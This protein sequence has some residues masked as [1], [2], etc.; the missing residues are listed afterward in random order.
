LGIPC[1]ALGQG[2]VY[3]SNYAP[4]ASVDAPVFD[5]NGNKASNFNYL[6][7]L[8]AGPD[9]SHLSLVGNAA[10]FSPSSPGYW[11]SGGD[12][13]L[14][15]TI[16][17]VAP[18]GLAYLEVQVWS[19]VTGLTYDAVVAAGGV[20]GQS[21]IFTA[22]TGGDTHGGTLPPDF[23]AYLKN[24]R[25]FNLTGVDPIPEPGVSALFLLGGGALLYARRRRS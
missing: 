4:E 11:M 18:G 6:A 21:D 2:T 13:S 19:R 23:P 16:D 25:S 15:R 8:L 1:A 24:L 17:S 10:I 12:S 3:F 14:T 9:A 20:H 22:V 7:Q 5:G